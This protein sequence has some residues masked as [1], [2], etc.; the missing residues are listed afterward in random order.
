MERKRIMHLFQNLR[1]FRS[2][3]NDS[4]WNQN[5]MAIGMNCR[6]QINSFK[7]AF[8]FQTIPI[9][10][11]LTDG[12]FALNPIVSDFARNHF[13]GFGNLVVA[14]NRREWTA[15]DAVR[16]LQYNRAGTMF[17]KEFF[18]VLSD[19]VEIILWSTCRPASGFRL[20]EVHNVF[21]DCGWKRLCA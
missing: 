9:S 7:I 4:G 17:A 19:A 5:E 2:A 18:Y 6:I 10:N 8:T 13:P 12:F 15:G 16:R 20:L 21:K 1:A 14:P 11:C 3:H